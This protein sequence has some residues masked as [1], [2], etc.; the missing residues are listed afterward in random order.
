MNPMLP[1]LKDKAPKKMF[2]DDSGRVTIF[3]Y[4]NTSPF[5][6]AEL[7]EYPY[8]MAVA[9]QRVKDIVLF[10]TLERS[11]FAQD[12]LFLCTFDS[13]GQHSNHGPVSEIEF[14]HVALQL[15]G[16]KL[17]LAL[18][19][20]P[21]PHATG[22]F[23]HLSASTPVS[24][25]QQR[26]KPSP[27]P[28]KPEMCPSC[29]IRAKPRDKETCEACDD[30][31]RRVNEHGVR[32]CMSCGTLIIPPKVLCDECTA[33]TKKYF[34]SKPKRRRWWFEKLKGAFSF[35]LL[36]LMFGVLVNINNIIVAVTPRWFQ[37]LWGLC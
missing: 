4:E 8:V 15:I 21:K 1:N 26:P 30:L 14:E 5:L 13:T 37:C 25:P 28:P 27:A 18:R 10:V 7:F 24:P 32:R 17:N 31:F 29:G 35:V 6:G 12:A 11:Q 9:D 33:E 19:E 2:R 16:K 34:K 23:R 20:V 36:I 3:L 22:A